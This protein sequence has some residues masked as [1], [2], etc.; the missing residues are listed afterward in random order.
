MFGTFFCRYRNT[1]K[2]FQ[3]KVNSECPKFI[4][5][6]CVSFSNSL[7]NYSNE[8]V[9]IDPMSVV[10]Q[11]GRNLKRGFKNSAVPH[12][13]GAPVAKQLEL[14]AGQTGRGEEAVTGKGMC[15]AASPGWFSNALCHDL[16]SPFTPTHTPCSHSPLQWDFYW[17][18]CPTHREWPQSPRITRSS[19]TV[20]R[21]GSGHP[22]P[23]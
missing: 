11:C 19:Q 14:Q 1:S 6:I 2:P 20:T 12:P 22:S 4:Q 3:F 23:H 10:F 18:G 17:A 9:P 15:R 5:E 13:F 16:P 7:N 21:S 8:A